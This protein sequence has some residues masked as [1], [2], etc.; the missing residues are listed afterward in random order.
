MVENRVYLIFF[1]NHMYLFSVLETEQTQSCSH[2]PVYYNLVLET[3]GIYVYKAMDD[4]ILRNDKVM[5]SFKLHLN[6]V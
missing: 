6:T 2:L 3:T 4:I 5:K 1:Q